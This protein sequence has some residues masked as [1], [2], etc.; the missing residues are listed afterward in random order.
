[1]IDLQECLS[2]KSAEDKTKKPHS[3][4]VAT[5]EA[6]YYLKGKCVIIIYVFYLAYLPIHSY[7][8]EGEG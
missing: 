2:V 4:E 8:R 1:M 5:P 3:F 6:T 7:Q